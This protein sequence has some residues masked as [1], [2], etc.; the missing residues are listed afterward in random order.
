MYQIISQQDDF[1]II[2]KSPQ[3]HFH[4]QDSQAGVVAKVEQDLAIKLF[5]VHRLDTPTS[6]LLILA[7]SAAAAAIFTQMFTAHQVQKY[8]LAIAKGKPKKKQGWIIGDMAKSRRSMFKLLRSQD[9]P[10]VTQFFCL[11]LFDGFRLYLLKPHSGKTH[12]LRVA[13]ASI[14]VPIFGDPLYGHTIKPLHNEQQPSRCY[15]HAYSLSF[16]YQ[17]RVFNFQSRPS[18]GDL[19]THDDSVS[20]L[21]AQWAAPASLAWPERK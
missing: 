17:G 18:Q 1:I 10:A 13:M 15:L 8:Y 16:T 4:S 14:G 3:V 9:N 6:G 11:P 12:Q 5:A 7:K 19:F 20:L 21:S 2:D